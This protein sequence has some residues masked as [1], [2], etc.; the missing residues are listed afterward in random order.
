MEINEERSFEA[1]DEPIQIMQNLNEYQYFLSL[2]Q[3]I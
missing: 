1:A 2:P 3:L